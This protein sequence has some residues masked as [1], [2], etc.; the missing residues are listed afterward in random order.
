MSEKWSSYTWWEQTQKAKQAKK[1]KQ[2][3]KAKQT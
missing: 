3:E 2:E 1:A